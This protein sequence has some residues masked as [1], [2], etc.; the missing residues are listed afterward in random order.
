[1]S[2]IS[3]CSTAIWTAMIP[4][5]RKILHNWDA[6]YK[7]RLMRS[8]DLQQVTPVFIYFFFKKTENPVPLTN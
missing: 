5:T 1:M 6:I 4:E 8:I 3:R 2:I 7:T